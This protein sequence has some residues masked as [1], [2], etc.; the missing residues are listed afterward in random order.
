MSCSYRFVD[1]SL[2][3]LPNDRDFDIILRQQPSR[4]KIS[5]PNE[6]DKR[7]IEP[8]PIIQM[9]WINFSTEEKKQSLQSP[10]YFVMVNIVHAE[11]P[12]TT[13]PLPIKEYLAG[14]TVSSLYRLRDI[15]NTDGGFF[16]FGDL[17]VR[18]QGYFR[19]YFSLFAM[20][21]GIVENRKNILSNAFMVYTTKQYPGP[22]ESTFLS[23]TFSDQGVKIRVRKNHQLFT[24]SASTSSS[25]PSKKKRTNVAVVARKRKL[26]NDTSI[27]HQPLKKEVLSPPSYASDNIVHFGRWQSILY[28]CKST[29]SSN[30]TTT[31]SDHDSNHPPSPS[32]TSSPTLSTCS[33][34]NNNIYLPPISE[35]PSCNLTS[36]AAPPFYQLPPLREIMNNKHSSEAYASFP[37]DTAFFK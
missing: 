6:R 33:S 11:N 36:I 3:Q 8:P 1:S 21:D 10:F 30:N 5:V 22:M 35:L 12:D 20:I 14:A 34:S 25:P 32:M 17:A 19:L 9:Q 26:D 24:T 27:C 16:V 7:S 29:A 23:R 31:N 37:I 13:C 18:K 2:S 28:K 15:D 4:A